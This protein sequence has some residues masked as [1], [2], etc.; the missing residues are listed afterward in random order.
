MDRDKTDAVGHALDAAGIAADLQH[1]ALV[2]HDIVVD[3][4]L[5]LAADHPVQEAAVVGQ[6]DLAQTL[7]D[8]VTVLHHD[9]FGDDAHIQQVAVEHLFAVT[10]ARVEACVRIGVAH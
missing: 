4:H 7:A 8:G 9:L 5:D 6:L 1:V 3:R 2:E 10:E